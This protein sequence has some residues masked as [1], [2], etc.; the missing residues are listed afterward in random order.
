M[1]FLIIGLGSMG[2]RRI[3]NLLFNE[4][5]PQ[6]IIGFDPDAEK[7]TEAESKYGIKT[8]SDF[9]TADKTEQP[10]AYIISTPPNQHHLYFLPAAK[11]KKHF[12]VEATTIDHG[13]EELN[14]LLDGSFV[15]APSCTFRYF[16]AVKLIKEA[17]VSG[18]I[19]KILSFTYHLG[20]YLPDWH[21]W[22]DYRQA[23]FAQKET[24]GAREMFAFELIWLTDLINSRIKE[25]KGFV[26]KLSGLEMPADDTYAANLLFEN[27]VLGN[28]MV[29]VV[30]RSPFRTLRLIGS[31][32]VLEW[33]W[34][35]Y[36]LRI[37][38]VAEKKWEILT[39]EKGGNEKGYITTEDMYQEEIKMFLEAVKGKHPYPYSFKEDHLIL[40]ALFELEKNN[41]GN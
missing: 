16:P 33:E 6:S 17:V 20:Q 40:K 31:E 38:S 36:Q 11:K 4:I 14:A 13:Y 25:I 35:S 41:Y 29:D 18:K 34:L 32:G 39:I 27:N 23:Y 8:Y 2:K 21:P 26:K 5:V 28:I 3:R 15:A 22:E 1:K 30:S 37:F 10:D 7:R 24:G 12:F 9:L 19:G